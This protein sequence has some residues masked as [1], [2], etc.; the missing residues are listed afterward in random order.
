[1]ENPWTLNWFFSDAGAGWVLGIVSLL[2]SL[3]GF[4]WMIRNKSRPKVVVCR[5]LDRIS[6]LR[7]SKSAK[8]KISIKFNKKT[9]QDLSQLRL[10]IYNDGSDFVEDVKLEIILE[11]NTSILEASFIVDPKNFESQME[12]KGNCAE[13][14]IPFLNPIAHHKQKIIVSIVCD[15]DPGKIKIVG[16]GKGWSVF[17][18]PLLSPK[19]QEKRA[20]IEKATVR[21]STLLM[22]GYAFFL[23]AKWGVKP[24]GEEADPNFNIIYAI[25]P[26]LLLGIIQFGILY[27]LKRKR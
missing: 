23:V 17:Q 5:E 22:I 18:I 27:W 8:E 24:L 21:I 1:M 20:R 26:L 13:I 19:E 4:L 15:G 14:I 11:E 12:T 16:G 10:E 7:I 25:L 6:L 3:I 9:I 2:G